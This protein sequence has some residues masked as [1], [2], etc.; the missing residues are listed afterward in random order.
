MLGNEDSTRYLYDKDA[1][2]LLM[3]GAGGKFKNSNMKK[4]GG[5]TYVSPAA[6]FQSG[7][8]ANTTQ[9]LSEQGN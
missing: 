5:G 7:A 1:S 6:F 3:I 4:A 2:T 8:S 9:K